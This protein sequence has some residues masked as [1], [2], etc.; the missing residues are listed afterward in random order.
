MV[1]ANYPPAARFTVPPRQPETAPAPVAQPQ[2]M[3]ASENAIASRAKRTV[4]TPVGTSLQAQAERVS[5]TAVIA[6]D[7]KNKEHFTQAVYAGLREQLA[8]YKEQVRLNPPGMTKEQLAQQ[9]NERI[10]NLLQISLMKVEPGSAYAQLNTLEVGEMV[11]LKRFIQ[12]HGWNLPTSLGELRNLVSY[13]QRPALP[14]QPFGNYGGALSWS[15]PLS[16]EQLLGAYYHPVQTLE[17]PDEGGLFGLLTSKLQLSSAEAGDPARV[18]NA[19][20]NSPAAQEFGRGLRSKAGAVSTPG[21]DNDWLL[22]GLQASLDRESVLGAV[23]PP[24]RNRVAGFDLNDSRSWGKSPSTVVA[25]LTEHLK[26]LNRASEAMAPTAAH[27]L[28]ARKAPQFLVRDMPPGMVI[29]SHSWVSLCTAVARIE[30]QA[31]GSVATMTY[32]QVMAFDNIEPVTRVDQRVAQHAQD[33]AIIDWAVCRGIISASP[34]DNYSSQELSRIRAAFDEHVSELTTAS[35]IQRADIPSRKQIALDWLK[36]HF[37]EGTDYE[38]KCIYQVPRNNDLP[39]PYSIVDLVIEGR[40]LDTTLVIPPRNSFR[41]ATA[42]RYVA[43]RW[44]S[45]DSGV[46]IANIV[47]QAKTMTLPNFNQQFEEKVQA[48]L[49]QLQISQFFAL[50]H[51]LTN[52]P[53][54]DRKF[55]EYGK[56]EVYR[57][58]LIHHQSTSPPYWRRGQPDELKPLLVRAEYEGQVHI[59]EVNPNQHKITRRPDLESDFVVGHRAFQYRYELHPR[60]LDDDKIKVKAYADIPADRRYIEKVS[61]EAEDEQRFAQRVPTDAVP[62]TYNSSRT[63][64]IAQLVRDNMYDQVSEKIV[65]ESRGLTTFESEVP[66]IRKIREFLLNLIPLRSAIVNFSRGNVDGGI[67]D[68]FFDTLGFALA[69]ASAAGQA[70][71]VLNAAGSTTA[72]AWSVGRIVGRGAIGALSPIPGVEDAVAAAGRSGLTRVKAA[73]NQARGA[74]GHYDVFKASRNFD[75]AATGTYKINGA[76]AESTAVLHNGKW[77]GYDP[78]SGQPF[79]AALDDFTPSLRSSDELLE[80]WQGAAVPLSEQSKRIRKEFQALKERFKSGTSSAE[81]NSGYTRGDPFSVKGFSSKLNAE[82]VMKLAS[83][84]GLSAAQIGALVRQQERLAVQHAFSGVKQAQSI[85]EATGGNFIPNPQRF[86]LSQVSSLSQGQCAALAKIMA[87]ALEQGKAQT[88]IENMFLAAAKPTHPASITFAKTLQDVQKQVTTPTTFHAGNNVRQISHHELIGELSRAE[89]STTLMIDS[90]GHSM[91]AG[92]KFDGEGKQFFFYDPNLGLVTFPTEKSM[93]DGLQALFTQKKPA[94]PYRTYSTSGDKLEFRVSTHDEG[95]ASK[96]S[97]DEQSTKQLYETRLDTS[98]PNI[99]QLPGSTTPAVSERIYVPVTESAHT[100]DATSTLYTRGISDCT[101]L[102]VLS[103]LKDGIYHKRTL[104]HLQGG[105]ADPSM[106]PLL[107]QLDASLANGGKVIFVGGDNA[108]S[109]QG[110]ASSLKQ[111]IADQQPLLDII[112]RQPQS[113]VIVTASGI[114]IKPDGTFELIEGGHPPQVLDAAMKREVF[115]RID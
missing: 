65:R 25:G 111:T 46:P 95:W 104:I 64:R 47:N 14:M 85:I 38:K 20:L 11:S 35:A 63:F 44:Q 6:P 59:Y 43:T 16:H 101:A 103:D 28:L 39:G 54:E 15:Q 4:E 45:N 30:A 109:A 97:V 108:R 23:Q 82:Q 18:I 19:L 40:L 32:A 55:L 27:L 9:S 114:D 62:Q 26:T 58:E 49:V 50:V 13:A 5:S 33:L 91:M 96:A 75:A 61:T 31:P 17:L 37:G 112:N 115:D 24:P 42:P 93:S 86:Y 41:A 66:P 79:G 1:I 67:Q 7:S 100:L 68:L 69:G 83:T 94:T 76:V 71:R 72:K 106:L 74:A 48:H 29:G 8:L 105:V 12:D 78:I 99:G 73:L 90:P 21:S 57:E 3:P 107:K 80:N 10:A 36:E 98:T 56:V 22:A 110:L 70:G 92:V 102:A 88:L 84:D 113:T 60:P 52:L 51:L 53:L 34:S 89:T 2:A 77:Y 81:Y 87:S